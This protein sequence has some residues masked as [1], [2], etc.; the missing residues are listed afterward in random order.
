MSYDQK[1]AKV[2]VVR[3]A[4][5]PATTDT[6]QRRRTDPVP[7]GTA[8]AGATA[9]KAAGASRFPTLLVLTLFILGCAVGGA[10][11]PLLG[12]I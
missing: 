5:A 11:L 9:A 10:A 3:G 7:A 1:P 8:G 2:R 6:P 12:I 4:S